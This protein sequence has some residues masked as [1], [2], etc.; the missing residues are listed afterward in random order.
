[1]KWERSSW[2]GNVV[3]LQ[4]SS[5]HLQLLLYRKPHEGSHFKRQK[6]A[7]F[8][9]LGRKHSCHSYLSLFAYFKA[10]FAFLSFQMETELP[11]KLLLKTFEVSK[12]LVLRPRPLPWQHN[13]VQ[14]LLGCHSHTFTKLSARFPTRPL[15]CGVK[16]GKS[17]ATR[18]LSFSGRVTMRPPL[19]IGS[20]R[21]NWLTK[22]SFKKGTWK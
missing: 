3:V 4:Q 13:Y 16:E 1:M 12:H 9:Y 10:V 17:L 8:S 18:T 11:L 14:L 7:A 20:D 19:I 6:K 5:D 21:G 15:L 22:S 2:T